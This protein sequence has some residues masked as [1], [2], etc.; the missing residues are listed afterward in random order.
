MFICLSIYLPIYPSI[1]PSI[2]QPIN[3]IYRFTHLSI[4]LSIYLSL[5]IYLYLSLP[6][7]IYIDTSIY[8]TLTS[9][10]NLDP[11]IPYDSRI[12]GL[13]ALCGFVGVSPGLGPQLRGSAALLGDHHGDD[14]PWAFGESRTGG[15]VRCDDVH[16]FHVF[17]VSFF[18]GTL[19][20]FIGEG[21]IFFGIYRMIVNGI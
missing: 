7:Y 18:H 1:H 19:R 3:H 14:R 15:R 17:H 21:S 8:I 20:G 6:I 2:N 16:V 5:S 10:K 11:I 13:D 12:S 9:Q 4:Y